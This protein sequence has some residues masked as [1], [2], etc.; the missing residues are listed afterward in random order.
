MRLT[1]SQ[2]ARFI[3]HTK[4]SPQATPEDIK[5]LVDEAKKYGF[6]SVCVSPFYVPL[7]KRL[8]ENTQIKVCATVGFP[9]GS[10]YSEVKAFEAEIA[11]T[12][13]ADEVDMVI[14]IG[15]LKAG[16]YKVVRD[17]V[18][19]VVDAF[20]SV[21]PEGIVKVILETGLLT[22]EEIVI[23]CK[24]VEEAGADFVKTCTGFGPRGATV[25]D[26]RIMKEAIGGR[27]GIKA[28]GGIRTYEQA[29]AMIEAGATRIGT[30]SGVSIV[31]GAPEG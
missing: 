26:I 10:T 14:N 3:D 9:L 25:E 24:L 23:G 20:R 7:A 30:S 27:L 22:K 17:D 8:L 13:G 11:A 5:K 12:E 4:L 31:L 28:A 18:R 6:Y 19:A 29:I 21:R 15:A 1:R 16:D 2:I